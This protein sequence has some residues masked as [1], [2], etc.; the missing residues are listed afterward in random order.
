MPRFIALAAA[1]SLG[2]LAWLGA[3]SAGRAEI[4]ILDNVP[5]A[6]LL[7][8]RFE[9]ELGGGGVTTLL[10]INNASDQPVLAHL[11]IWSEWWVPVIGFD[12][13]LTGYDVHTINLRDIVVNGDLPNTGPSNVLSPQGEFSSGPHTNFGGTCSTSFGSAPNYANISALFL[14][15]LQQALTGQPLQTN[16][17][18]ASLP[19]NPNLARGYVTVDVVR[20]CAQEHPDNV[21]YF[22]DGGAGTATNENVLWGD[23]F[24][25]DPAGNFAQGWSLVHIEADGF[26]LG[27]ADGSCDTTDRYPTTFYCTLRNPTTQP[28]E[29]NREGLS[30]VFATRYLA[31]GV[32]D[33]GTGLLVW[34]DRNGLGAGFT[35]ACNTTPTPL[36]QT[37][38]VVFD[39]Q[40]NPLIDAGG[41]PVGEPVIQDNPFPWGTNR[42]QVGVDLTVEAPFGWLFLNLNDGNPAAEYFRQAFVASTYSAEGRFSVGLEATAL[43]NLT[44]GADNRRGPRNPDPTLGPAPHG[45]TPTLFNGNVTP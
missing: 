37:Q 13:Y 14:Q 41:G 18:C 11:T 4:G 26:G 32:F 43:N 1:V 35:R 22:I 20:R 23:Y 21:N 10:A 44:L 45:N 39:E 12:V 24:L 34:R 28:G 19:G 27:V 38:I 7:L 16:G 8:P 31:G 40:E 29:D 42:A 36:Q 17:E 5:A 33:G 15:V 30:S 6:T 2:A 25:V 9:V 3:P